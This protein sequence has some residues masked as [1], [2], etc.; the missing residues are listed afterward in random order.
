[1]YSHCMPSE[2]M[3]GARIDLN[4]TRIQNPNQ[5]QLEVQLSEERFVSTASLF[6]LI[7]ERDREES[8]FYWNI[9]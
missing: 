8:L 4:V 9:Q 5:L 7:D 6:C 2:K 3:R 1:M